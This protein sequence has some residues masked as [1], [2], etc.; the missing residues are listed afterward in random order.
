MLPLDQELRLRP[1]ATH[2]STRT[3]SGYKPRIDEEIVI[4][5]GLL[6]SSIVPGEF[7]FKKKQVPN[8]Y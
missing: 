2:S 5:L 1:L 7:L 3:L 8:K 6:F 4:Q